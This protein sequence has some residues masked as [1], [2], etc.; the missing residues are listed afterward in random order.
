VLKP[1]GPD[2][3]LLNPVTE[4]SLLQQLIVEGAEI[5]FGPDLRKFR[6]IAVRGDGPVLVIGVP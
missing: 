5:R 1:V 4:A 3:S 2:G 6:T